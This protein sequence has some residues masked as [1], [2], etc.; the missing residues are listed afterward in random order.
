MVFLKSQGYETLGL[1]TDLKI[2]TSIQE[3]T[4]WVVIPPPPQV[5]FSFV[6]DMGFRI[7]GSG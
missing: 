2:Y 7:F 5:L 1:V 3:D 4:H 6:Q